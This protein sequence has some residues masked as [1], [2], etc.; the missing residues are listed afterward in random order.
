[1]TRIQEH[2]PPAAGGKS[3][4]R[5]SK[6]EAKRKIRMQKIRNRLEQAVRFDVAPVFRHC[7]FPKFEFRISFGFRIS[8]F[9]FSPYVVDL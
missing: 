6:P 5:N 7:R 8:D 9:E 3:E 4:I 1:M 2:S